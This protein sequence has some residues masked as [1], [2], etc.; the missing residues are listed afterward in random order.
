MDT[1][2]EPL[3]ADWYLRLAREAQR[4]LT[5]LAGGRPMPRQ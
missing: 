3:P 5:A 1:D 4:Q 2:G